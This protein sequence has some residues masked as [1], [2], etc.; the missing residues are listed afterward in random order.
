MKLVVLVGFSRGLGKAMFEQ[1]I[2]GLKPGERE[3][4]AIG[5]NTKNLPKY[6][7]VTYQEA[8]LLEHDCWDSLSQ[9]IPSNT[10]SLDVF[11]NASVIEPI[12]MVGALKSYQLESA[13]K[14][15]YISPMKLVNELVFLK[16]FA[17]LKME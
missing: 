8:D 1:L 2:K 10:E 12:A 7:S 11:I 17:S 5:R 9:D 4:L 16:V 13:V 6:E 3:L 14:V 15:N